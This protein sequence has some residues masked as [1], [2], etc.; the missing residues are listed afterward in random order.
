[1]KCLKTKVLERTEKWLG[2]F[3]KCLISH[4]KFELTR[5]KGAR[6]DVGQTVGRAGDRL[7]AQAGEYL[8][9]DQQNRQDEFD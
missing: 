8:L 9:A 5:E 1:M 6:V 3:A 7:I 4:S 2:F